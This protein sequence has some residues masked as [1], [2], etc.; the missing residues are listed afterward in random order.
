[1]EQ[2]KDYKKIFWKMKLN[3]TE[4][5]YMNRFERLSCN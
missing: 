1:M 4:M 2:I 5:L 3:L